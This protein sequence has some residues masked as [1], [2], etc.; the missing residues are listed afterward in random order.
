MSDSF[1]PLI[2]VLLIPPLPLP[3]SLI[4]SLSR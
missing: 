2:I 3:L 1:I 4:V